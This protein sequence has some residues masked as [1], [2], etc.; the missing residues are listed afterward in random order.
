MRIILTTIVDNINFGTYL[1]AYATIYMFQKKGCSIDILNYKRPYLTGKTYARNYLKKK[2]KPLFI[3][4]LYYGSYLMLNSFM[5]W[6]VKRFLKQKATLTQEFHSM[7]EITK[8]LKSYDLY[9]TGSDQVWNSQHNFGV[10][11]VF[12]WDSISGRKAAYGASIGMKCFPKKQQPLIYNLLSKYDKI[13]VRESSS[14]KAL[15]EIGIEDVIQVLDPTLLIKKEVW[16]CI[17]KH[18]FKKTVPYLL[19]YSVENDKNPIVINIAREIAIKRNLAIY[20][21]CP[22]CKLKSQLKID[23]VFNFASVEMFLSLFEQADYL[24]VSSFHGTAFAIN[25]NKQFVTVSPER[26]STRV[27]S[28][29]Q[30]F[31]LENQ[32]INNSHQIP[33][34][35]IVYTSVNQILA[36]ERIKSEEF[37][38]EIIKTTKETI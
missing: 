31:H 5:I 13:S 14:V 10:D 6:Q 3:R 11:R 21:V 25:F 22:T 18:R 15:T 30:L 23:K 32:Y 8:K 17:A 7:N 36:T 37:I 16:T 4:Y 34:K 9:L 26:F 19:I 28:L 24:V 1:Q 35:D 27:N 12:F 38:D 2:N 20:L 29:L 33:D